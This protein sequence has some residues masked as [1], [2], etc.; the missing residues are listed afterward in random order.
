MKAGRWPEA[1]HRIEQELARRPREFAPLVRAGRLWFAYDREQASRHLQAA[2]PLG[3]GLDR[4]VLRNAHWWAE[5]DELYA[6]LLAANRHFGHARG[7]Y[8]KAYATLAN[9]PRQGAYTSRRKKELM[10]KLR[11][12]DRRIFPGQPNT[13]SGDPP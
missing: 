3:A 2:L 8:A 10:D 1:R 5:A 7:L 9:W 4:T 13:K 6:D 11:S 12:V